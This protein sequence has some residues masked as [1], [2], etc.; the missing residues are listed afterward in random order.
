LSIT[1]DEAVRLD[2]A[3]A[4][5][6]DGNSVAWGTTGAGNHTVSLLLPPGA[7]ED[8]RIT[9]RGIRDLSQL[10]NAMPATTLHLPPA[11]WPQRDD[12][13]VFAWENRNAAPPGSDFVAPQRSGKAFWNSRGGMDVRGGVFE[14]PDVGTRMVHECGR[15]GA[16]TLEA[17]I[18]PMVPPFDKAMRPVLS[19]EDEAG[20]VHL[21]L[22]QLRSSW[23]L[24]L[25]TDDNPRGTSREQSIMPI[26]AGQPHHVVLG[27]EAGRFV[28]FVDGAEV[29][30]RSQL[31]GA[32]RWQDGPARFRIGACSKLTE[33]WQGMVEQLS[34]HSRVLTAS[35]AL[36]SAHHAKAALATQ[37]EIKTRKVVARL[38]Q[39]TPLP[40]LEDIRPY[41]EA[42]VEQLYEVLPKD[43]GDDE[44]SF[45]V[46]SHLAV[47]HWVWV[48]AEA[49]QAPPAKIGDT[50]RLFVQPR[51]AHGEVSSLVIR[52]NLPV[53]PEVPAFLDVSNW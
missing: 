47:T 17:I 10:G 14:L 4:M 53:N 34:V 50:F 35:E 36:A 18:A 32:L 30:V 6:Q 9:L 7:K 16:F 20:R 43:D 45:P 12:A 29:W 51:Q 27:Y 22:L 2:G 23:S 5:A 24:W 38:V 40:K 19:L 21:A 26:R 46:G 31:N 37:S 3:K 41:R 13:L 33:T 52:S 42:L 44:Q 28:L 15:S 11:G 8:A 25:A 48:N 39:S 1:F 49:A